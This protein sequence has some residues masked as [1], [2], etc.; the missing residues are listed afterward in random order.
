MKSCIVTLPIQPYANPSIG[1]IAS[2]IVADFFSNLVSLPLIIV[3]SAGG[4]KSIEYKK[5]D[6]FVMSLNQAG[7]N[8]E[9]TWDADSS[10]NLS[11]ATQAIQ[12]MIDDGMIITKSIKILNCECGAVEM[13]SDIITRSS[14][15]LINKSI[16]GC[17][18]KLCHSKVRE[19]TVKEAMFFKP[20]SKLSLQSN[21]VP[22]LYGSE[23][24]NAWNRICSQSQYIS[25]I[26]KSACQ[27]QIGDKR[28]GF[29]WDFIWQMYLAF[30]KQDGF[31]PEFVLTSNH[32]I[33]AVL[34][35]VL[36]EALITGHQIN[37]IL[38]PPYF[39]GEKGISLGK[40]KM[41]YI[42][43]YH[44]NA[45]RLLVALS[46]NWKRKESRLMLSQLASCDRLIGGLNKR[47]K[48]TSGGQMLET[49]NAENALSVFNSSTVRE[50]YKN[51]RKQGLDEDSSLSEVIFCKEDYRTVNPLLC[52]R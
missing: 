40:L 11:R 30:L 18:C 47:G 5:N 29:D 7:V 13:P 31:C 42:E 33:D 41:N 35:A 1:L 48:L 16:D 8:F 44:K 37:N 10:L 12:K 23:F 38:I 22:N 52:G 15:T 46:L 9:Q 24:L 32:T 14:R 21:L 26:R 2:V 19:V 43:K 4:M 28:I 17:E 27:L 36:L 20:V 25:R 6:G 51:I 39:L 50:F 45:F 34:R 3:T 49:M